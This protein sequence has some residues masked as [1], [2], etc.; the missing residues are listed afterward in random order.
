MIKNFENLFKIFL[1]IFWKLL[2]DKQLF[3]ICVLLLFII[4]ISKVLDILFDLW[5]SPFTAFHL[6]H[7]RTLG[8]QCT[9]RLDVLHKT[10]AVM[11][12]LLFVILVSGNLQ[13][14]TSMVRLIFGWYLFKFSKIVLCFFLALLLLISSTKRL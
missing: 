3:Q 11:L 12:P 4:S 14:F 9:G 7:F 5:K 13:G 1:K 8:D 2:V 10:S 6:Y